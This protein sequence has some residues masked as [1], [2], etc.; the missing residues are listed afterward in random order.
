MFGFDMAG[1]E[2]KQ[3]APNIMYQ[4]ERPIA[5]RHDLITYIGDELAPGIEE[6]G[7]EDKPGHHKGRDYRK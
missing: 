6:P 3:M 1:G 7:R 4:T 2:R 5:I